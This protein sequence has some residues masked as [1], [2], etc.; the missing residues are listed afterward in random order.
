MREYGKIHSSF[1]TSQDIRALSDDGR[2]LAAYLLTSPHSNMLGCFRV[3]VAYVAE[4]L[5][6][7]MER[8]QEGFGELTSNHFAT[9]NE[10]S[11]WVV[12]HKF[13]KWNQPENPNVVRAAEKLFDQIPTSSGVKSILAW[14]VAEFEPRFSAEKLT[15]CEPFANPFDSSPKAYRK[16]EPEPEPLPEPEPEPQP[17]PTPLRLAKNP[18]SAP[19]TAGLWDSYS[20]AYQSRYGAPPVRNAKVNGQLS[21]LIKRLG[22]DEAPGV[23]A[24]YV[25]SNNRYYVQKRHAVDCLLADAEGLRTEWATRRRVTETGAREADRLQANGDMWGRLIEEAREQEKTNVQ[26]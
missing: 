4:D 19:E 2:T 24:W 17:E 25:A 13:L 26:S 11:K 3:P 1:W 14:A 12:I 22:S 15:L 7:G 18:A 6:W 10:G 16:P 23:A 20:T 9:F 21:N 8:V 5:G